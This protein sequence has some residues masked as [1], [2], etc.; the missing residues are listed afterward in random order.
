MKALSSNK[1]IYPSLRG[2][3]VFITGGGTGIGENIVTAFCAQGAKVG[4]VDI[5]VKES[6]ELCAR[7]AGETNNEPLFIKCDIRK[8]ASLTDAIE[9]TRQKLGN[10]SVLI[11]NAADD[12]RINLQDVTEQIWDEQIAVNLRPSF[13]ASVA[14]FEQMKEAGGGSI[15]NFGSICWNLKQRHMHAYAASKAA[16]TGLTRS[17]ARDFGAFGVRVNTLVPGWVMTKRQL[18]TYVDKDTEKWIN[19]TQCLKKPVT[20]DDIASMALFL[21]ADES[22]MISAET[23]VVDGGLV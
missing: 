10:I 15:I 20:P 16:M 14:V 21:A 17:L 3:T 2:R 22:A 18:E 7:I 5:K 12:R 19:E 23:F 13:F 1:A 4:F 9:E 8:V 6:R 11:N